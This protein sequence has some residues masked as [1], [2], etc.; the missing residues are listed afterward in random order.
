MRNEATLEQ[1]GALYEAA[2]R[3]KELKPWDRFWDM[4][5]IGVQSEEKEDTVF[6]S[7][8]GKGGECYGIAV[9]EGYE[10]FNTYMMLAMQKSMNLSPDYAMFNQ[11][12]LTCYWGNRDELTNKQRAVIKELG[13]KYRG[14]NQWLYFLS[15]EPGYWPFNLDAKEVVRMIEYMQDLERALLC[16]DESDVNVDFESGNMF[17][18]KYGKD[19]KTWESGEAPLPYT[20]FQFGNLIIED[21]ELLAELKAVPR[22]D[23]VLEA[24]ISVMGASVNDKKYDR[25]ANP[26]LALLGDARAGLIIKFEMTEPGDDAVILLAEIVT[27][28]ILQYGA[29][30]EIRVSN[31]IVE[32]ALRQICEVCKIKLRRVKRIAGLETFMQEMKEFGF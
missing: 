19:K 2:T 21:E 7:I 4:E 14:K 23:A 16:Y 29:P 13:Y 22:C 30:A 11:K 31:V 3:I 6:F 5:L 27:G 1:W 20:G 10:G 8:L 26:S 12:N 32:S 9:Y 18:L 17:L 24:G 15:F 28:F 25:P